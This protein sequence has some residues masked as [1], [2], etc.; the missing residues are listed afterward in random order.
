MTSNGIPPL[1]QLAANFRRMGLTQTAALVESECDALV[2]QFGPLTP[3]RANPRTLPDWLANYVAQLQLHAQRCERLGD[4]GGQ[5]G[6]LIGASL[7]AQ[8]VAGQARP[9]AQQAQ[10]LVAKAQ[11]VVAKAFERIEAA[12]E[13]EF[14]AARCISERRWQEAKRAALGQRA[15]EQQVAELTAV[16]TRLQNLLGGAA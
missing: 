8:V 11:Y 4:V 3:W 10:G 15:R 12:R 7:L 1:A 5:L 13:A 2:E 9:N 14:T 6:Y 16:Q